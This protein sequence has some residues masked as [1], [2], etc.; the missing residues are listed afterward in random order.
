MKKIL[1]SSIIVLL[2]TLTNCKLKNDSTNSSGDN[3]VSPTLT[4]STTTITGTVIDLLSSN[5]IANATVSIANL[6]SPLSTTTDSQGAFKFSFKLASTTALNIL[7]IAQ[8]TGYVADTQAVTISAGKTI[9]LPALRIHQPNISNIAASIYLFSQ[10]TNQLGIHETGTAETALATFQVL[11]STGHAVNANHAV[12]V[13]FQLLQGPGGG[14][15]ISPPSSKTDDNGMATVS[16]TTG[17]IAGVVQIQAY[18]TAGSKTIKSKPIFFTIYGGY[19]VQNNFAVSSD[20]V[21]YPYYGLMNAEIVF[22]ALLGDKYSNPVRPNTS[23]YFRTTNGVIGELVSTD[24]LGRAQATLATFGNPILPNAS[25][26]N[27]GIGFFK[28][29]AKTI[30]ESSDTIATSTLRLLSGLPVI[31]N[32]SPTTFHILNG[33]SQTFTFTV[34]DVNGNPIASNNTISFSTIG[35]SLAVSPASYAVPD[36]LFGGPGITQ[37]TMTIGDSDIDNIKPSNASL[38]IQVTGSFGTVSYTIP[39]YTE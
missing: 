2:I 6:S 31:S 4:D 39:G 17:T 28:V 23:V 21:N 14:E 20:K 37:Y 33:G 9:Q 12:T 32:V 1:L 7:V 26:P 29:T 5:L 19:P 36:A 11:D 13:N 8:K 3:T 34:T 10:S 25:L 15:F 24:A 27:Q 22:T 30:T 18:I 35:G 38:I 16:I